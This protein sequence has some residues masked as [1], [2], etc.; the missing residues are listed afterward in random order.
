MLT[1]L[2]MTM[3]II[4]TTM[5]NIIVKITIMMRVIITQIP[6][7]YNFIIIIINSHK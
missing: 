6:L 1:E 5:I 3:M 4:M 2:T 7:Q